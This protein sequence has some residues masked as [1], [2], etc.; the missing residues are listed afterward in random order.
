[1]IPLGHTAALV[2][3]LA[4]MRVTV[5]A[6]SFSSTQ[7]RG[8]SLVNARISQITGGNV[9]VGNF[10]YPTKNRALVKISLTDVL[11]CKIVN[12]VTK[13]QILYFVAEKRCYLFIIYA[14]TDN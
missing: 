8:C 5:Y 1:M 6:A 10:G 9:K 12:I 13:L 2:Q 11:N 3:S 4:E 7:S 14:V